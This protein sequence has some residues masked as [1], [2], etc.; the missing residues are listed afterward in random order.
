MDQQTNLDLDD[1]NPDHKKSEYYN[2]FLSFLM[3]SFSNMKYFADKIEP[4]FC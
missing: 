3:S 4:H 1:L 2:Y